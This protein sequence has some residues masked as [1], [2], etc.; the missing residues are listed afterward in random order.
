MTITKRK[1][2]QKN[3]ETRIRKENAKNTEH[4]IFETLRAIKRRS[5]SHFINPLFMGRTAADDT[6]MSS[7]FYLA[8][9]VTKKWLGIFPR[10]EAQ[11]V[12][13]ISPV[14]SKNA[15]ENKNISCD[16]FH[17]TE[18]F[19]S[20]LKEEMGNYADTHG[21]AAQIG[22]LCI[23]ASNARGPFKKKQDLGISYEHIPQNRKRSRTKDMGSYSIREV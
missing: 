20:I 3:D 19:I 11:L 22:A 17:E 9:L 21:A 13:S 18:E 16:T 14:P 5:Q 8:E 7:S 6:S 1:T 4:A 2:P 15:Y 10:R 23:S 12:V